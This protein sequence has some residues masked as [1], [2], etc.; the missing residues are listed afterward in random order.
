VTQQA[1]VCAAPG[2]PVASI[3][4]VRGEEKLL[5]VVERWLRLERDTRQE[6]Q[7]KQLKA[8]KAAAPAAFS[9]A[10]RHMA[11]FR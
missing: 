6:R 4:E 3:P 9:A 5:H 8:A 2:G 1:L 7:A 10:S 11:F